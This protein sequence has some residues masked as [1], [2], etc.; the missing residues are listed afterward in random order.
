MGESLGSLI[1]RIPGAYSVEWE[2]NRK[3]PY[4]EPGSRLI[5]QEAQGI[6]VGS[7]RMALGVVSV[8]IFVVGATRWS[9][10]SEM[11]SEFCG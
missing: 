2:Y 11:I 9:V 8:S 5:I 4:S 1:A 7:M 10:I 6:C 3:T